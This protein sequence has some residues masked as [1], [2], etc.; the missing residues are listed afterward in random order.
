MKNDAAAIAGGVSEY[1][2]NNNGGLPA[3]MANVTGTVTIGAAGTAQATAKINGST[4]LDA[5]LSAAPGAGV[6]NAGH[7]AYW[8]G[9]KCDAS[10]SNRAIAIYYPIEVAGGVATTPGCVES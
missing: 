7:I 2:S 1:E 9:H 4:T 5:A 3:S 8:L 10:A 6:P